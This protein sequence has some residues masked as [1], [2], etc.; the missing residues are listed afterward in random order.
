[1]KVKSY[2]RLLLR[3]HVPVR[4]HLWYFRVQ[5]W[6]FRVV[7]EKNSVCPLC[8]E[9]RENCVHLFFVIDMHLIYRP[10]Q[11][12]S[13]IYSLSLGVDQIFEYQFYLLTMGQKV[14]FWQNDFFFFC[15]VQAIWKARNWKNL[16]HHSFS[17][18]GCIMI[19]S[20]NITWWVKK[21]SGES[22][23]SIIDMIDVWKRQQ[24]LLSCH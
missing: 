6:Y 5:F 20:F 13:G 22:I 18:N 24:H 21:Q 23:S 17:V 15:L 16:H 4:D 10:T 2:L 14:V 12:P 9:S 7:Q 3:D 11:H 8:R 19:F 1:M